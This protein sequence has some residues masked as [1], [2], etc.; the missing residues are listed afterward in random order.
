MSSARN[1]ANAR[2]TKWGM[3]ILLLETARILG[4]NHGGYSGDLKRRTHLSVT[5]MS[6]VSRQNADKSVWIY[7]SA[8][9][10]L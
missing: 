3:I 1:L 2:V 4:K 7:I 10:Y 8:K 6:E 9:R 5:K